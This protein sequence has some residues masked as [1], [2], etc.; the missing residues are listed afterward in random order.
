MNEYMREKFLRKPFLSAFFTLSLFLASLP[1]H[2]PRWH[3]SHSLSVFQM[4]YILCCVPLHIPIL[5][6]RMPTLEHLVE[7]LA[8]TKNQLLLTE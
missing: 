6:S 1:P 3:V 2:S 5:H 7:E 4:D 8:H